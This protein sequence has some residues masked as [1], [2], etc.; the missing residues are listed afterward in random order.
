[1]S[2]LKSRQSALLS[3]WTRQTDL[4]SAGRPKVDTGA[5]TNC[6]HILRRPVYQ[7]EVE[8]VLKG[9]S[10]QNLRP[11]EFSQGMANVAMELARVCSVAHR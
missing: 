4:A 2:C 11:D 5:Q 10:I 7:V 3:E 6:Q 8:V 9:W 1:M